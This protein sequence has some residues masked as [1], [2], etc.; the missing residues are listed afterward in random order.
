MSECDVLRSQG[1]SST[2]AGAGV[3]S[4]RGLLCVALTSP[5]VGIDGVTGDHGVAAVAASGLS[6][7]PVPPDNAS[8]SVITAT[9]VAEDAFLP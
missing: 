7:A 3:S 5:E 2:I 8:G 4:T 9:F 6:T 1:N